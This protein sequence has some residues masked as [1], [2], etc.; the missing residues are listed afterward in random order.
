VHKGLDTCTE[1]QK[2]GSRTA[3]WRQVNEATIRA[4]SLHADADISLQT[5]DFA[6]RSGLSVDAKP[7]NYW[8]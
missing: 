4:T 5:R 8:W 1:G 7:L 2:K 6:R 3:L